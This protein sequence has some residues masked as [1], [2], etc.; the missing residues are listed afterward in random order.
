LEGFRVGAV[1][2]GRDAHADAFELSQRRRQFV[3]DGCERRAAPVQDH[4]FS[5]RERRP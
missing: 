3:G 4:Y 2:V 5:V 1:A